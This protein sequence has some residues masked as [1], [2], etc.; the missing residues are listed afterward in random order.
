MT[1]GQAQRQFT[2][3]IGQLIRYAYDA[4]FELTFGDAYRDP[5]RH[6]EWGRKVG[7]SAARSQHKRRLAVDFNLF[8]DGKYLTRTEDHQQLG[9]YWESIGGTWGGRWGD[10]NHYSLE[11]EGF[12]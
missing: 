3:M 6:G 8:K 10:G 7:Y 11:Y 12:K 4:G 2:R 9:E 5:R 1:L